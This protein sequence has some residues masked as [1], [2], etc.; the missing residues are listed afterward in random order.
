M[1]ASDYF[2]SSSQASSASVAAAVNLVSA[3][4]SATVRVER[5][6]RAE[7]AEKASS[8]IINEFWEF[9]RLLN[10]MA[11]LTSQTPTLSE[12]QQ[13]VRGLIEVSL[14]EDFCCQAYVP[15]GTPGATLSEALRSQLEFV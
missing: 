2:G 1:H 8:V 13:R 12:L 7:L 3:P 11:T 14:P 15:P 6:D 5:V 4:N 9:S 10:A